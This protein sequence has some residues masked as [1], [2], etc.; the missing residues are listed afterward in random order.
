MSEPSLA[1]ELAQ[2]RAGARRFAHN[3][4]EIVWYGTEPSDKPVLLLIH[5]FPTA[6]FDWVRIWAE[7]AERFHLIAPDMIGFGDSA[8][9][10]GY[11][12]S[13]MDQ[14]DLCEALLAECGV[15]RCHVLA[16]DYGDTVAQELLARFNTGHAAAQLLSVVF[17][18]GGLF[19]ETHR[20][21][22]TQRLLHSP[23]GGLVSS[24]MSRKR[25]D[26]GFSLVFAEAT[27]PS[28]EELDVFWELVSANGGLKP[29]GHR[30]IRYIAE[31]RAKRERWVGALQQATIPLRVI[32]GADDPVS[33]RHM[34]DRYRE[35]VPE[36]DTVLLEAVGHYP[37]WEAPQGVLDA[38]F[39]FHSARG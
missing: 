10:R 30:L 28:A 14:A 25:F 35:L 8:K 36:P 23:L 9:P 21:T 5:G 7:L 38:F 20:A 18:N 19:P 34:V 31:R 11:P 27:R 32:D 6:A 15:Q 29:I 39:N 16:H 26:A 22:F 1:A 17:L 33:G 3:G 13:I 24:L 2:W 4:H 12:Y 37:Q